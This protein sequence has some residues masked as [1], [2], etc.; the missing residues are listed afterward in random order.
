MSPESALLNAYL[1][2]SRECE[3]EPRLL[4]TRIN[5]LDY[6]TLGDVVTTLRQRLG[7]SCQGLHRHLVI[8]REEVAGAWQEAP[9]KRQW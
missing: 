8:L 9:V 5:C 2:P 1:D 7:R 4:G 6:A 3:P